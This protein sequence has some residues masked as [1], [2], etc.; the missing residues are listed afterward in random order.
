M[1]ISTKGEYGI[2]AML[3]IA[4]QSGE[5]PA[6]S[7]EIAQNQ[8]IP[9]PYLRQILASLAKN[10]LIRSTRGPHGGHLL[11]RPAKEI[12]LRDILFALEGHL[13]SVD[14]VLA[15]PCSIGIG[16]KHCVIREVFLRVKES[17]ESI[18]RE[19]SLHDLVERQREILEL[20]IEVPLDLPLPAKSLTVLGEDPP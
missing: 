7:H 1:K 15:Q 5:G 13:T 20:D 18:M 10:Q 6:T 2:R 17:V 12:S 16:T 19:T 14:H 8:A 4:M 9:E 11:A 3:F